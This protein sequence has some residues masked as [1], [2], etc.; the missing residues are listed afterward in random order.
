MYNRITWEVRGGISERTGK[1][2][3]SYLPQAHC[4]LQFEESIKRWYEALPLGNGLLGALLWGESQS[5]RLSIDRGDLWDTTPIPE[6]N[7]PEFT[8]R[9][10]VRLARLGDEEGIR[11]IFDA[12]YNHPVPTKLPAGKLLLELLPDAAICSRLRLDRAEAEV[13]FSWGDQ[14]AV[15]RSFLHAAEPA[16]FLLLEG[17]G[18]TL[19]V[20][21]P[22]FGRNGSAGDGV[23]SISR[24]LEQLSYPEA[25][26]IQDDVFTGFVQE[27]SDGSSYGILAASRVQKDRTEIV[28]TVG[29]SEDGENWLDSCR[30][31]LS[32]LLEQGY[33][34]C[35][36]AHQSWW[37]EYWRR[38]GVSLPDSFF[39]KNW[40]LNH[41]LLGSCSRK[42]YPPM[43]LQ[44]VWTADNGE[45]PPWKGD[46][47]QDLNTQLSYYSYLKANHL[48]EG[49]SFLDFLWSHCDTARAFARRFYGST[50]LCL[51]SVMTLHG[52]AL[53][54]WG[55]Y[56][57]S[58]TNQ[59]WLCQ[60]FERH[61]TYT[62]DPDF[63]RERAYPYC[64]E[65]GEFILGLLEEGEDGLLQLPVSSSPEIHDDTAAS[66]LTPNSNYDLALLRYLFAALERMSRILE[67]GQAERW[68]G[69][70]KKLP[71]LAVD[72][73]GVL[74]VSPT[75]IPQASHRHHSHAMAIH[76]LRLLDPE[77]PEQRQIIDATVADLERLGTGLWVGYSFTWLAEFFVLQKNGEGAARQLRIFWEDFCS[78]NGFHL[79]G[80]YHRRGMS[81]FHYTPFTLEG[82]MCSADVLQEM[83][84]Y[85]EKGTVELFPALPESWKEA[86]FRSFRAEGGLLVSAGLERGAVSWVK[87][88]AERP[89]T[90]ELYSRRG[91][92]GGGERMSLSLAAGEVRVLGNEG[93]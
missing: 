90:L 42:G 84:L 56:S 29:F 93:K 66:W 72:E 57:L 4:D 32:R 64:A 41:Y 81:A 5:F 12:P 46:Y 62:G 18:C 71:Q 13:T 63:L 79:N 38:S 6:V 43:P 50:G 88:E 21:N 53:G 89:V 78:P 77:V 19:R 92:P 69:V 40:Y 3:D 86:S 35:F 10:M 51:P 24:S 25:R 85:S 47:H 23:P 80:D 76:P 54:G 28:Y 52:E 34:N 59:L 74:M 45:L 20:E 83:L 37:A 15:L 65:T 1:R 39:E 58:P 31:R 2:M 16:G 67:D 14:K 61:Y 11:R 9:E 68:A 49:E 60:L 44:G 7:S 73:R 17:A 82:N 36:R 30:E 91:L 8:Y 22:A 70:L 87:L 75:E 55:M 26:Q 27:L 48:E 33:E